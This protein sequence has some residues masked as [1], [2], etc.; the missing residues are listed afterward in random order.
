[1]V[2]VACGAA[3]ASYWIVNTFYFFSLGNYI[4]GIF[5]SLP[6]MVLPVLVTN[7]LGPRFSAYFYMALMISNMGC[8]CHNKVRE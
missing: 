8:N 7:S 4:A 5:G 2:P 3:L 6:S 1:L